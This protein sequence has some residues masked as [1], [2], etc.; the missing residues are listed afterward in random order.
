MLPLIDNCCI[1]TIFFRFLEL[2]Q[3]TMSLT[4][5]IYHSNKKKKGS[6]REEESR[7]VIT[8]VNNVFHTHVWSSAR[9]FFLLFLLFYSLFFFPCTKWKEEYFPPAGYINR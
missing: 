7:C 1:I 6:E 8:C 5:V 2:V 3:H 9:D 4:N